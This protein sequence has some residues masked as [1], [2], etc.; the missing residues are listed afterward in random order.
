M[1]KVVNKYN[2]IKPICLD[3]VGLNTFSSYS[4]SISVVSFI[5]ILVLNLIS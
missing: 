5:L 3:N 4:N 2:Y 1:N